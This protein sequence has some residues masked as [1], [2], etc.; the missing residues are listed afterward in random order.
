MSNRQPH[1]VL[2]QGEVL[3]LQRTG[4]VIAPLLSSASLKKA[5]AT[6]S[7]VSSS[8]ETLYCGVCQVHV[9]SGN[10]STNWTMHIKGRSHLKRLQ[11]LEVERSLQSRATD[12][13]GTQPVALQPE[14]AV[15]ADREEH[16]AFDA[17]LNVGVANSSPL[18][19]PAPQQYPHSTPEPTFFHTQHG[20]DDVRPGEP[21]RL[22]SYAVMTRSEIGYRIRSGDA[23]WITEKDISAVIQPSNQETGRANAAAT[24]RPLADIVNQMWLDVGR[25][26]VRCGADVVCL[27]HVEALKLNQTLKKALREAAGGTELYDLHVS[28]TMNNNVVSVGGSGNPAASTSPQSFDASVSP[29][30]PLCHV[31][32]L[33]KGKVSLIGEQNF[34]LYPMIL[35]RASTEAFYTSS[36]KYSPCSVSVI[37]SC[38]LVQFNQSNCSK[39]VLVCSVEL[40]SAPDLVAYRIACIREIQRALYSIAMAAGTK[41]VILCGDFGASPLSLEYSY[42]TKLSSPHR[43]RKHLHVVTVK[44]SRATSSQQRSP[45]DERTKAQVTRRA[46]ILYTLPIA[47]IA[48][49]HTITAVETQW[50][51]LTHEDLDA[52]V[53]EALEK[54][55]NGIGPSVSSQ[56]RGV[57]IKWILHA[58]RDRE[59]S[60]VASGSA[61]LLQADGKTIT[62]SVNV[63]SSDMLPAPFSWTDTSR[64]GSFEYTVTVQYLRD[65]TSDGPESE[66]WNVLCERIDEWI[67]K[68]FRADRDVAVQ[69]YSFGFYSSAGRHI[70]RGFLSAYAAAPSPAQPSGGDSLSTSHPIPNT[71]EEEHRSVNPW[72]TAA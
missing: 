36:L 4:I 10:D 63:T 18:S 7:L 28:A 51:M 68:S 33:R 40:P 14:T 22:A 58:L 52:L 15:A 56:V 50:P 20:S 25:K 62:P 41:Y 24:P 30:V 38:I 9:C 64:S 1:T 6:V 44:K 49:L 59:L 21:F 37:A 35:R 32:A 55:Q 70:S 11:A 26:V 31:F 69:G 13:I 57:H 16:S 27:Q 34:S 72:T 65:H 46:T 61:A 66:F 17:K 19:D 29:G 67:G 8:S 45:S 54:L 53:A 2:S 42:L 48:E 3:E 23:W 43:D 47:F 60:V 39:V 5:T 12:S 71:M